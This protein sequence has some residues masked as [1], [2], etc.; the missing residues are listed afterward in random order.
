MIGHCI[1][2]AKFAG[3]NAMAELAP[4]LPDLASLLGLNQV[5]SLISQTASL[6][7]CIISVKF[8]GDNAMAEL[9]IF[10]GEKCLKFIICQSL[11][12]F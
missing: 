11:T 10:F 3:D 2:S 7:H 1:I 9:A 5:V 12:G 6:W 4:M 8:V